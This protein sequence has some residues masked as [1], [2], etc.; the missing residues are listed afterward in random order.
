M[1]RKASVVMLP[2]AVIVAQSGCSFSGSGVSLLALLFGVVFGLGCVGG[3]A[4]LG[5]SG[6]GV[7]VCWERRWEAR[8]GECLERSSRSGGLCQL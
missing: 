2:S 4:P 7:S 5:G 6:V 3:C 8:E 1:G